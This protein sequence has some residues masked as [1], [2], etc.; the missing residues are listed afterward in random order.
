MQCNNILNLVYYEFYYMYII[1]CM[2]I[3]IN[4]LII[5]YKC[6]NYTNYI[7]NTFNNHIL[8]ITQMTVGHPI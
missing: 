2:Y 7:L 4:K 6:Y 5:F 8:T 1:V 3:Y